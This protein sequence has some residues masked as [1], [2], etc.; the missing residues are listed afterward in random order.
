MPD[1]QGNEWQRL[2]FTSEPEF[3]RSNEEWDEIVEHF[4]RAV[5]SYRRI[6]PVVIEAS[7]SLSR[8]SRYIEEADA[9]QEERIRETQ[10]MAVDIRHGEYPGRDSYGTYWYDPSG[11]HSDD[12][13]VCFICGR[14]TGRIDID[15]HGAF[16]NSEECNEVIRQDLERLNGGPENG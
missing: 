3:I 1:S 9:A 11:F 12:P 7:E 8:F 2:G 16:C 4:Q 13:H 15:F 5:D 14:P 10:A 6:G